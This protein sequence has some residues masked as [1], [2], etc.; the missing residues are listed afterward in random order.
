MKINEALVELLEIAIWLNK[1]MLEP[2][3][4]LNKDEAVKDLLDRLVDLISRIQVHFL[5][6]DDHFDDI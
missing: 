2:E 3:N 4:K 6:K 1:I 5:T